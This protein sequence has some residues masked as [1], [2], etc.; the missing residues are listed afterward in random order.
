MLSALESKLS[1]DMLLRTLQGKS[2]MG[3]S[4]I[5]ILKRSF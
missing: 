5:I 1:F 4:V 2:L 3:L